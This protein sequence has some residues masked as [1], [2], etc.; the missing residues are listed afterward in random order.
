MKN[1]VFDILRRGIRTLLFFV[2]LVCAFGS[3]AT[4]LSGPSPHFPCLISISAL[5][6]VYMNFR[7]GFL[8]AVC[9]L[10]VSRD[11]TAFAVWG[12][13][14]LLFPALGAAAALLN[15]LLVCLFWP[16]VHHPLSFLPL[17]FLTA[18]AING[19]LFL[20]LCLTPE[21]EKAKTRRQLQIAEVWGV[22]PI[23]LMV[24]L[25]AAAGN[26]HPVATFQK[27]WHTYL[28]GIGLPCTALSFFACR[29]MIRKSHSEI[30]FN[31]LL[32]RKR[33]RPA[34]VPLR[35]DSFSSRHPLATVWWRQALVCL[36]VFFV[37]LAIF[38]VPFI[39]CG[40]Q[41]GRG[42]SREQMVSETE[43]LLE[44]SAGLILL[45]ALAS[46]AMWGSLAGIASGLRVLRTLP[47]SSRMLSSWLLSLPLAGLAGFLLAVLA[48]EPLCRFPLG[49]FT[50]ALFLLPL[51]LS[52]FW[53]GWSMAMK[54]STRQVLP[55]FLG[56]VF[57]FMMVASSVETGFRPL[58]LAVMFGI[59]I[60]LCFVGVAWFHRLIVSSGD[61][62]RIWLEEDSE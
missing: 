61:P 2:F 19:I 13:V 58:T 7:A 40:V 4:L 23:M 50:Q 10:P 24:F 52:L 3:I 46:A 14:V 18:I 32:P 22:I 43:G 55:Y 39:V 25:L 6:V 33:T 44:T 29:W 17:S 62:Y 48:L 30:L 37:P 31:F 16:G 27:P 8:D 41:S 20:L 9:R 28:L 53:I 5:A 42:W 11:Q 34:V 15:C 51:L 35:A 54:W 26:A 47:L 49:C 57:G 1:L 21:V 36:G 45:L 38:L 56:L 60:G 59:G 12:I